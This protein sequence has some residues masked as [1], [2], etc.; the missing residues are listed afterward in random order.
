MNSATTENQSISSANVAQ[1]G[2]MTLWDAVKT[3]MVSLQTLLE[4]G[5]LPLYFAQMATEQFGPMGM[6]WGVDIVEESIIDC[7]HMYDSTGIQMG[8]EKLQKTQVLLWYEQDGKRSTVVQF[9]QAMLVE[10][11]N[12]KPSTDVNAVSKAFSNAMVNCLAFLG[13]AADAQL[14][15]GDA[16][17]LS[18]GNPS[19]SLASETS[20][21]PLV[22]ADPAASANVIAAESVKSDASSALFVASTSTAQVDVPTA[23]VVATAQ[24]QDVDEEDRFAT[25]AVASI[26]TMVDVSRL[27]RSLTSLS[28]VY[29]KPANIER[30]TKAIHDRLA[31]LEKTAVTA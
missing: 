3:P 12:G 14:V 31:A 19:I 16:D 23:T 27:R 9:G 13:F 24:T 18:T 6:G 20:A 30:V 4:K 26:P 5:M 15:T 25:T 11:K 2:K 21:S 7:A 1:S 17:P 8:V 10:L 29:K 22:P 28:V